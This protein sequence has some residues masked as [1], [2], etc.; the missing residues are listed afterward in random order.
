MVFV[1]ELI[2]RYPS[3]YVAKA[4]IVKAIVLMLDTVKEGGKVMICGN[5]GSAS[6]A[7]HIVGELMKEFSIKRPIDERTKTALEI[8]D[9]SPEDIINCLQGAV[10]ALSLNSQT[11]LI[12]AIANDSNPSMVFAQQLYGYGRPGDILIA[13]STS[14]NSKNVLNAVRLAK[15]LEIK[16]I[17]IGGNDGGKI[18]KLSD[19]AICLPETETYK[20]QELTLPVYHVICL[21]VESEIFGKM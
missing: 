13:L 9:E 3:L 20:I 10:P 11:S 1:D 16:A 7:E 17:F 6:D 8:S 5:G 15:A 18:G 14:G 12:T 2:E 4:E 21:E 19:A